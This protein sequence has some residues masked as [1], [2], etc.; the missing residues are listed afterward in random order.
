V[1]VDATLSCQFMDLDPMSWMDGA[2]LCPTSRRD[3]GPIADP[4]PLT[5]WFRSL[6]P[7]EQ[8]ALD[9]DFLRELL[10][11]ERTAE[12]WAGYYKDP[13]PDDAHYEQRVQARAL[14]QLEATVARL[15]DEAIATGEAS[16][17]GTVGVRETFSSEERAGQ[18]AFSEELL[19]ATAVSTVSI[20][21]TFEFT[22]DRTGPSDQGPVVELLPLMPMIFDKTDVEVRVTGVGELLHCSREI[23]GAFKFAPIRYG[24]DYELTVKIHAVGRCFPLGY[25]ASAEFD[26]TLAGSRHCILSLQ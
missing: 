3:L 17:R 6:S 15:L 11:P 21:A 9:V 20:Q 8:T 4:S 13:T 22:L 19:D 12:A 26:C 16:A 7:T 14:D 18:E 2:R 10:L 24:G 23:A 25:E 5:A 1:I